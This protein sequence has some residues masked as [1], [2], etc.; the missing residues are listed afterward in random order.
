M[1][2]TQL[3]S[4]VKKMND[5]ELFYK[6]YHLAKNITNT[7]DSFLNEI[8]MHF[9]KRN[10]LIIPEISETIPPMYLEEWFFD[11]SSKQTIHIQ[12]HNRYSPNIEHK[13]NFFELFYVL[14]GTCHQKIGDTS[15]SMKRG[16][17]CLIPPGIVH[18]ISVFDESIIID[19][20]IRK[21]TF[22][23]IFLNFLRSDNILSRFFMHNLYAPLAND[24]IIFRTG[25]DEEIENLVMDLFLEYINKNVYFDELLN[26]GLISLFAKMLRNYESTCILPAPV[27]N[28]RDL[29]YDF[30]R[31]IKDNYKDVSLENVANHFNYTP[32]YTSRLIRKVTNSSF[33][34][35]LKSTRLDISLSLLTET[36]I[37]V[38][39]ISNHIG[40]PN[41]EHFIRT[42]K[43][44]YNL[45][46]S[47]YRRVYSSNNT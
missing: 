27:N 29:A 11:L 5:S 14:D 13:H 41:P 32:E 10:N 12:K 17:I 40:Y 18:N 45:T 31:F 34:K 39:D 4:H 15:F 47:E 38:S 2:S 35:I 23:D 20:L 22:E 25:N 24:Y 1:D 33:T 30:V 6:E 43:K 19:I 21:S 9:V 16:D 44:A 36:N 26:N 42:F 8:D 37:S 3:Y 28:Q 7:L 46:P